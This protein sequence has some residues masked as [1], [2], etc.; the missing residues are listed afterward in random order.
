MYVQDKIFSDELWCSMT[1]TLS[2]PRSPS[3]VNS[4]LWLVYSLWRIS[5]KNLVLSQD[6]NL[7]YSLYLFARHCMDIVGISLIS[8]TTESNRVKVLW[9]TWLRNIASSYEPPQKD[10]H[11]MSKPCFYRIDLRFCNLLSRLFTSLFTKHS[12]WMIAIVFSKAANIKCTF[13]QTN[14][15]LSK[16]AT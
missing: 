3:I 2:F 11:S 14:R 16:A 5:Y 7:K 9:R 8:L 4:S 15:R 12:M 1:L 10:H 6:N 13:S